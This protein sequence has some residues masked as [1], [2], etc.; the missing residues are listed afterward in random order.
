MKEYA[1]YLKRTYFEC[2]YVM[3]NDA[4]MAKVSAY[5]GHGALNF[6]AQDQVDVVAVVERKQDEKI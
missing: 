6:K 4:E 1:V 3:A 5:R 2:H